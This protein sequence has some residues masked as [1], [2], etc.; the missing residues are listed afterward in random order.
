MMPP[1]AARRLPAAARLAI[2]AAAITLV[3][4]LATIRPAPPAAGQSVGRWGLAAS[5]H[6]PPLPAA[7]IDIALD[8]TGELLV[9]DGDNR[10]VQVYRG[11]EIEPSA[12]WQAPEELNTLTPRPDLPS[13]RLPYAVAADPRASSGRR[14]VLW[15][16]IFQSSDSLGDGVT[17]YYL[18][19]RLPDGRRESVVRVDTFEQARGD[20][21]VAVDLAVHP[22]TGDVIAVIG[23]TALR[24]DRASGATQRLAKIGRDGELVRF[25]V[26]PGGDMVAA[27][28]WI[29]LVV[30]FDLR[31][32]VVRSFDLGA[33]G[34]VPLA[35]A[36][37]AADA[38][39]ALVRPESA[40]TTD[41]AL[42]VTFDAA[43]RP[44]VV[45]TARALGT[46]PP[47]GDWPFALAMADDGPAGGWAVTTTGLSAGSRL[48]VQG[49][50]AGGGARAA[51]V[52]TTAKP[53]WA[54]R[55][56]GEA[57]G[58][59]IALAAPSGSPRDGPHVA[60]LDLRGERVVAFDAA[61]VQIGSRIVPS[62]TLDI[63]LGPDGE[64]YLT[65]ADG[66]VERRGSLLGQAGWS[67]PPPAW[68]VPVPLALGGRITA[69]THVAVTQ[70]RGHEAVLLDAVTGGETGRIR[71]PSGQGLWPTDIAAVAPDPTFPTGI[72]LTADL[73]D[74][75]IQGWNPI[76]PGPLRGAWPMGLLAGPR[77]LAAATVPDDA[78]AQAGTGSSTWV[79]GLL[80]DGA[81]EVHALT[82]R[83]ESLVAR[84]TPR[85]LDGTAISADDIALD[86][87]GAVWLSDRRRASLHL[88]MPF[89]PATPTART[90]GPSPT[91][92]TPTATPTFSP[93]ACT[94]TGDKVAGP[95]RIVLGQT[96][97]V[98]LTL[99][100][101]CPA[102]TRQSGADVLLAID[103]S[104]SMAG[105]K[106]A[107]AQAAARTFTEL[108]DVRHHRV[109]LVAFETTAAVVAPL[110]ADLVATIDALDGLA[111][112]GSTNL[113][114]AIDTAV[115]HFAA[116]GRPDALPVVVLLTDGRQNGPGDPVL[117]ADAARRS[118]VQLYTIGLGADVNRPALVAIAG[119][120]ER[121]FDAPTPE[122]LFPVYGE[123]LRSVTTS[124][125][126]NL[127]I[128]DAMG[129]EVELVAGSA[130]PAAFEDGT[131]AL[132]W[133][134]TLLPE[135]GITLT[136]QI[137]P[138][139]T[140]RLRTNLRAVAEYADGDGAR[141]T[142]TFPVP[143]IEVVAPTPTPTATPTSLPRPVYLPA[144]YR[145][146]CLPGA[147]RNDVVV[148]I[149][150]SG[151]MVGA[152]LEAA[153]AAARTFVGLLGESGDQA[154]VIGFS[155]QPTLAAGLTGDDAVLIAA[156]DGLASS[157]GTRIDR[158]LRAAAGELAGS[159]NRRP[160]S[161]GVVVLLSD[162]TQNGPV[163]PVREVAAALKAAGTLVF[164][165]GLGAD[166]DAALLV[167]VASPDGYR[168]AA[169]E[170]V[171]EEIYRGLAAVVACR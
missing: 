152:K 42:L 147:R 35:V 83:D 113:A 128:D 149:D 100:A 146:A 33:S 142:F 12:W 126:G 86:R 88:F 145:L 15:A 76:A 55:L 151:S 47:E 119:R 2:C 101:R 48:R 167:D 124:L 97:S 9:A 62:N 24:V 148:V 81:V 85:L 139:R 103:R 157:P 168:A 140:G 116:A 95:P 63:A 51:I 109:G 96:A 127:V 30:R 120:Q 135:S 5:I 57:W 3:A 90:P 123:I 28:P 41:P 27:S 154:A 72:V 117:A 29:G 93:G 102:T 71:W 108:L 155:E 94:V 31:G 125:A 70:P 105:A 21:G 66:A 50:L 114:A 75:H 169:D 161:R 4:T 115:A 68:R 36:V 138:L 43:G 11:G 129:G 160:G 23:G 54:P 25:A 34:Y 130:R 163:E 91:S 89:G 65:T 87:F 122:D 40:A 171:L 79:A 44:V 60:A 133:G 20:L 8:R 156:I 26:A 19:S 61:G 59:G 92:P 69:G 10:A 18:E 14:Y 118:G 13:V 53:A 106:L 17:V 45:W 132:Q 134:R 162:G 144:A 32:D 170:R 107:A 49:R 1:A 110:S 52:G 64:L 141:R 16:E 22:R 131:R 6:L 46:P 159:P 111:P 78:A 37:D 99:A 73:V 112:T 150:T 166:V 121:F 7:P 137:R 82:D 143:E 136:Y 84:F 67:D 165:I 164:A 80:A 39:Y 98:T 104:G 158:A 77:R 38:V 74:A 153:K 56:G 58:S